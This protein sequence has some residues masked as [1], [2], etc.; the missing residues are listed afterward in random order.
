[1]ARERPHAA[2]TDSATGG[3]RAGCLPELRFG[4]SSA[5]E[6]N[7]PISCKMALLAAQSRGLSGI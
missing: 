4:P 2:L 5:V 6:K 1:M 7:E 3:G